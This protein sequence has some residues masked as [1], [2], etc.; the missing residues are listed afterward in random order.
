MMTQGG[1]LNI[2]GCCF[3]E[4]SDKLPPGWLGLNE[5]AG[6]KKTE[7]IVNCTR[8]EGGLI[9]DQYAP[10]AYRS[11]QANGTGGMA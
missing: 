5:E 1:A 2:V 9:G 7:S 8:V 6:Y 10:S 4:N 3:A 11:L